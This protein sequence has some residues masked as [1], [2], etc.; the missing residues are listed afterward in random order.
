MD[1]AEHGFVLTQ[2]APSAH[3]VHVPAVL[4]A[5]GNPVDVVHAVPTVAVC[6]TV[7]TGP[8]VVQVYEAAV[9]QVLVEVQAP[10]QRTQ[11]QVP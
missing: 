4:H 7:Q 10:P 1:V 9:A 6:V 2:G 11:S 8:P 5:P 3:S